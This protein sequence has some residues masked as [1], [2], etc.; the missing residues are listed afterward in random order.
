M[1]TNSTS[2]FEDDRF[3]ET[4]DMDFALAM[5][6]TMSTSK[7]LFLADSGAST[8]MGPDDTG[9]INVRK[10]NSQVKVGNSR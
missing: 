7:N 2:F 4:L 8:H 3:C 1:L 10:I 5:S 6:D 9:M